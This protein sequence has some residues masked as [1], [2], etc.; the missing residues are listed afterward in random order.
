MRRPGVAVSVA[1]AFLLAALFAGDSVWTSLAAL[2]VAGGWG[3]LALTG[4]VPLPRGGAPLLGLLLL[5]A[6]WAGLS[7]AWSV[8]A[9]R[10]WEELDRTLVFTA[11]LVVGLLLGA[12]AP[13]AS[14]VALGVLV[15]SLGAAS[16]WALAGKAIPALF[17]D[18]GRTA[19]LRDPIGYWNALGLAAD[20]LLVL[21]L[22][23]A[24]A[25]RS[26][27]A[28]AGGALLAYAAGVAVLLAASRAGVAAALLGVGLLIW[29]RRDRV[30]VALLALAALLPAGALA[31]WAFS[32]PALVDD[33][34][35]RADRVADGTWF[36]LLLVAG[37]CLVALAALE[38][39]RRPLSPPV[40]RVV[41]RTLGVLA[42][43]A[44]LGAAGGAIANVGRIA[45]EFRGG[46]VTN[47]PDRFR[48]LS[49]NN[50]LEWWSEAWDIFTADPLVGAGANTFEVARKRY[51]EAA[52]PVTEPH[53]VPLQFLAGLG[54]VGAALFAALVAAATMAAVAARRRLQGEERDAA[55]A[56]SVAL[57]LWLAH[58]LVDYDWDFVAVTGPALFAAGA[59]AS[60]G[61][62]SSA[63]RRPLAALAVSAVAVAGIASVLTPWL[64]ERS[65]REVG[66]A[67]DRG[68][69]DRAED[70]A[71]SAQ[72]LD[73]LSLA[74]VLALA[75]VEEARREP[76]AALAAYREAV[77]LQP[78]NP[79]PWYEL[80][81]YEFD[82]GYRC[83]AYVDLNQA[84]T[85]DPAG[86]QWVRG[87]PLD[88]ARAWVNRG[89]C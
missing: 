70:L 59:L 22:Q 82:R 29:L 75:R 56:L 25:G 87:G 80:G 34:Y 54:L 73:P 88:Q 19:R 84:Y 24:A 26:R 89:N 72:S 18:G 9:D 51:R 38:L 17:P 13:R 50:R 37:G 2:L 58:A 5:V 8:A 68:Q 23:L 65:V 45:D 12:A 71:R 6:A 86:R 74:P 31:A 20:M 39:R 27:A 85:L 83:S 4:R 63:S 47:S 21:A 78:E 15:A 14:R 16:V 36:G 48:S 55:A 64:A 69:L 62:A 40:R 28:V 33:G 35:P 53:S 1:T 67:I 3:A 41:A 30:H 49:S 44:V 81:L 10:S 57:A 52:S 32:R 77:R 42:V 11:F 66:D 43:L 46:E 79:E 60:A 76:S 7:T 61:R